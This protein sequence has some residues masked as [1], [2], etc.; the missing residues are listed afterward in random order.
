MKK[1]VKKLVRFFCGEY[2]IYQIFMWNA[3]VDGYVPL[4]ETG[5]TKVVRIESSAIASSPDA[6]IREQ[7]AYAGTDS[8]AYACFDG[9]RI[10]GVCFYWVAER[11]RQRNYWPLLACDAK[12]VQIVLLP[13]MR[14]RGLARMLIMSSGREMLLQGYQR[15][16]ARI[17]HSN[18]PS[19]CAF[20]NAG[21]W[22]K[23]FVI[24][25]NPMRRSRPFRLCIPTKTRAH[26]VSFRD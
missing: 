8:F 4:G 2:S 3:G 19:I 1:F 25:I 13:E 22:R 10:V 6:L 26:A 12:L 21:W 5:N 17:W 20:Q 18:M 23:A 9:N 15:L 14:G 7:I 24:E 11:Y 16:F